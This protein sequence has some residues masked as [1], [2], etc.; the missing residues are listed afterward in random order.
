[1]K[2]I[3]KVLLMNSPALSGKAS[4][5]IN[6]IPQLGLGYIAACL[7]KIGKEVMICDFLLEGWDTEVDVDDNICRVGSTNDEIKKAI[8]A[9]APEVVGLSCQF[10]RQHSIYLEMLA[11]I[12]E[13]DHNII[14]V[15]GGGHATVVPDAVLQ[16]PNCD[17]LILGEGEYT[18]SELIEALE[19]GN[20]INC[21]DGIGY[22]KDGKCI[23]NPKKRWIEDL[24]AIPFPA[25][26]LMHLQRYFGLVA[27]HGER[28]K[29]RYCPIITSRG[30]TASCS[31][32][33]AKEVWG[34]CYR[35]RSADKVI[36]E[37]KLLKEQYG[38]EEI[39]FEDDNLTANK[40]RAEE[41][42]HKMID[43]NLNFIWD[44]PNGISIWPIDEHTID[45]MKQ[46]GCV[47][48]NFPVESGSERVLRKII[49]KPVNL[50]HVKR[51]VK[52][53]KKIKL[54]YNF[55]LVIGMPGETL[56]E[57]FQSIKFAAKCG[58][59]DVHISIA[60]PYPGSELLRICQEN[61]FLK[62]EY[63]FENLYIRSAIIETPDFTHDDIIAL[64]GNIYRYLSIQRAIR[65][66]WKYLLMAI[67][68]PVGLFRFF[69]N[70][71]TKNLLRKTIKG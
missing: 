15:C 21:L 57:M 8:S 38:I 31:F 5:D 69:W 39:M 48:I 59:L 36:E 24:D 71:F 65:N 28:H 11:L 42:F 10:S 27:S 26:H 16:S 33:T 17:Y 53:C 54:D 43:E 37:M 45:L 46:S 66:P 2:K 44:T 56:A 60:T 4:R 68:D 67:K 64:M 22:K 58:A 1:M 55:F 63:D 25:Y 13:I 6:P 51:L 29:A 23:I 61:G 30:C 62:G 20:D 14:T 35:M 47:R 12:K 9:F 32:C 34:R 49:K 52:Y 41:I 3:T 40:K 18:F 50:E 70:Y 7:E 19:N